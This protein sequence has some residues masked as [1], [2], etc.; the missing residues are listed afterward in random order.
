MSESV[1]GSLPSDGG[2]RRHRVEETMA[3]GL[4]VVKCEPIAMQGY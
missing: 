1:Y 4:L 3:A 2:L